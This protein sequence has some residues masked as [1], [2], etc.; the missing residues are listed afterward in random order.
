[1]L[2]TVFVQKLT[3]RP[4]DQVVLKSYESGLRVIEDTDEKALD[5]LRQAEE[6]KYNS[7]QPAHQVTVVKTNT[8]RVFVKLEISHALTD[9]AAM[10]IIIQEMALAYL[11]NSQM[12]PDRFTATILP[13]SNRSQK[14][15]LW[16]SGRALLPMFDRASFLL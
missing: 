3:D 15:R 16:H 8:N 13:T 11:V 5:R 4:Y 1:M 2:R 7:S 9:G 14:T 6:L 10:G 12:L